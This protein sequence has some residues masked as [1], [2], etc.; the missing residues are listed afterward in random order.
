MD[1]ARNDAPLRKK[2]LLAL[3]ATIALCGLTE[4][5]LRL[6]RFVHYPAI[7]PP[8]LWN[9]DED[10]NL[11]R[12]VGM[13]EK[14][15]AQLWVPKPG[16]LVPYGAA[17]SEKINANGYR[18]PL[19]AREKPPG[20]LRVV[21][22][23]DS[24]TFGMGVPYEDTWCAQLEARLAAE[25]VP[26]EVIDA[27]VIGFT[28]D[29]GLERY[30]ALVHDLR[31]DVVI[32]A[33]GAV[34]EHL[35]CQTLPDRP[36]I[37]ARKHPPFVAT[38]L[39]E[40]RYAVRLLHL[41]GWVID[42]ASGQDREAMREALRAERKRQDAFNVTAGQP[43]WK[44]ERRV[45]LARF[46][47]AHDELAARARADEAGLVLVSMPRLPE[48]EVVSPVLPLY[49]QAVADAAARAS[50][51]FLDARAL[52]LAAL[53]GPPEREWSELFLDAYHPT[54]AGHALLAEGLVPIVK[55][56]ARARASSPASGR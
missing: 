43:D 3:A 28:I 32:S 6:T 40:L 37:D 9:D 47:A 27:G 23:G 38:K 13:F 16:A 42:R 4:I 12:G 24:S 1:Q 29:Q 33:F 35:W 55:S 54:R 22:L 34:N 46:A 15:A 41:A 53:R 31:P 10:R 56:L 19:R 45:G 39:R 30:D 48:R 25:G 44:G 17:Q 26:A 36:K 5:A 18:G 8:I 2:L 21:A 49:N 52:I 51:G 7:L 50:A 14:D 20:V 11:N